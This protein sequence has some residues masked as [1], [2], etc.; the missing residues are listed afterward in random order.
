MI[1]RIGSTA[2]DA[3][4]KTSAIEDPINLPVEVKQ[5]LSGG[6]KQI[7]IMAL[8]QALYSLNHV[9]VPYVIDTPFARIDTEHRRKILKNF[10]MKLKGHVKAHLD[11]GAKFLGVEAR[12]NRIFYVN[13][14][15]LD[16]N[17]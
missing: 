12:Y 5:N 3:F 1:D 4:C 16:S 15:K 6:E 11:R 2:Y 14:C 7:F 13:L 8:Y 9:S 17:L 10:F